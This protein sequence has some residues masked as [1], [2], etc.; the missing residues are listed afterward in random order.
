[1]DEPHGVDTTEKT[2]FAMDLTPLISDKN[3]EISSFLEGF[4]NRFKSEVLKN[5]S[6]FG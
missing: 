4:I 1:M 2:A 5:I 6:K 3:L